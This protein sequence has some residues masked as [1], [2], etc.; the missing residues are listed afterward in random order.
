MDNTST[1]RKTDR[2][3]EAIDRKYNLVERVLKEGAV[4]I[5][6]SEIKAATDMEIRLLMK[7]DNRSQL[8]MCLKAAGFSVYP[9]AR[10]EF[11]ITR[12]DLFI[13]LPAPANKTRWLPLSV[14]KT[15]VSHEDD[16]VALA[17]KSGALQ[18]FL[19][20][21]QLKEIPGYSGRRGVLAHSISVDGNNFEVTG[22]QLQVDAPLMGRKGVYIGECKL[23]VGPG[24]TM[25]PRQFQLAMERYRQEHPEDTRPVLG[26]AV[27]LKSDMMY[28][29]LVKFG[30]ERNPSTG[31]VVRSAC[32]DLSKPALA[33]E[34][35]PEVVVPELDPEIPFPQANNPGLLMDALDAL[36]VRNLTARKLG[37][38]L[39]I[40]PREGRYYG[41]FARTLAFAIRED[42]EYKLTTQ[43]RYFI[44]QLDLERRKKI[45]R[46]VLL[47]RPVFDS[48]IKA[49]EQGEE[50]GREDIM[51]LIQSADARVTGNTL[52]RR[53]SAVQAWVDWVTS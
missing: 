24:D 13:D 49:L 9:L 25:N 27:T 33:E 53:A 38:A 41:D 18:E 22:G 6:V 28:L 44:T 4:R 10:D 46:K 15:V 43:G 7:M 47:R 1:V 5:T 34:L 52:S 23:G 14:P 3:W 48:A 36:S 17:W 2:A 45:I 50:L 32:Y 26:F 29:Y 39:D 19:G 12:R 16:L 30:Q 51:K 40:D 8:P 21:G 37:E 35:E 31:F 42:S 20:E 11:L